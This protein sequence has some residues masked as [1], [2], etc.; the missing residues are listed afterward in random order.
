MKLR[1]SSGGGK[2]QLFE[3]CTHT[4]QKIKAQR[5][6]Y[7][8]LYERIVTE[9]LFNAMHLSE[10]EGGG[11]GESVAA[12]AAKAKTR[13]PEQKLCRRSDLAHG[14]GAG[15]ALHRCAARK[16]RERQRNLTDWSGT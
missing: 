12:A 2:K 5:F 8:F 1:R 9:G 14:A 7:D 10:R 4:H 11:G 13:S 3:T 6:K 16:A 15:A